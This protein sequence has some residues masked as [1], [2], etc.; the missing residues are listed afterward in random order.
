MKTSKKFKKLDQRLKA[1]G[2]AVLL[3]ELAA[4]GALMKTNVIAD[5]QDD[6]DLKI[7]YLE[8]R[9][10]VLEQYLTSTWMDE[11]KEATC[12]DS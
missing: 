6:A 4:I 9:F 7:K 2:F 10:E 12:Q 1:L 8:Y 5:K 3:I 11:A